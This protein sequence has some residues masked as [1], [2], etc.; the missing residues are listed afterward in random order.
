MF[1]EL[2]SGV[3][4]MRGHREGRL[5]LRTHQVG[6]LRAEVQDLKARVELLYE[7]VRRLEERLKG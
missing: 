2:L 7:D 5:T 6:P 4:A 1:R 3:E